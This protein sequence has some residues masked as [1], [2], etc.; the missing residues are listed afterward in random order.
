MTGVQ[1]G[2]SR[3]D[4]RGA[5]PARDGR[6]ARRHMSRNER[7]EPNG[8]DCVVRAS[9]CFGGSTVNRIYLRHLTSKTLH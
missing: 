6:G 9:R 5:S 3:E 8:A 4:C 2:E 7:C 1:G